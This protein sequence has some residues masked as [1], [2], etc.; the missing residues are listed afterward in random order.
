MKSPYFNVQLRQWRLKKKLSVRRFADILEVG[1]VTI[2]RWEKGTSRPSK[3]ALNR[4][5]QVGFFWDYDD[6]RLNIRDSNDR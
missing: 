4:L 5:K 6:E 1:L 3:L 2:W